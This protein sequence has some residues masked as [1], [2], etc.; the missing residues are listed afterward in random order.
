MAFKEKMANLTGIKKEHLPSSY[1]MIGDIMML[2]LP[3]LDSEQKSDLAKAVVKE[4]PRVSTVCEISGVEGEMRTPDVKILAGHSTQTVHK[5]NKIMYSIDVSKIMFSKGNINERQRLIR[6]IQNH[7]T[8][9]DMFAGIGYFSLGIAKFSKAKGIFAIEKNE[10]SFR[11]LEYN[12]KLNNIKNLTPL[13]GDCRDISQMLFGKA[14]RILMGY[15]PGTEKFLPNAIE[16]LK[17][18]GIIHFHNTYRKEELW[19]APLRDIKNACDDANCK[20]RV[21]EKKKVKS[22]APNVF[23]I[24]IDAEITKDAGK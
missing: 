18:K 19:D 17:A 14:D 3:K 8:I 1:Q 7:E 21:I 24:V 9:V 5:E 11:A 13:F 6:K 20:F 10:D 16:M 15:L 22:Y 12:I 23:H 2:K 4:Y